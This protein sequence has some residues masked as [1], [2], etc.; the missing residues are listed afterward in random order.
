MRKAWEQGYLYDAKCT[1]L[2]GAME[3]EKPVPSLS[4]WRSLVIGIGQAPAGH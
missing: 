3:C 4:Q 2:G 1:L